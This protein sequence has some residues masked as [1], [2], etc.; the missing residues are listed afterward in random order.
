MKLN[1]IDKRF[2][3]EAVTRWFKDMTWKFRINNKMIEKFHVLSSEERNVIIRK[4]IYKYSSDK[5]IKSE[6]K[7]RRQPKQTLYFILFEYA[8]KYGL[9]VYLEH[10]NKSDFL[11]G[12]YRVDNKWDI[13]LYQGQG[14]FI[15]VEEI[16]C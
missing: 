5:Y 9:N 15:E 12:A 1:K 11:I 14:S 6:S 8:I 4:I 3:N 2:V 10:S 7:H 13:L 16:I